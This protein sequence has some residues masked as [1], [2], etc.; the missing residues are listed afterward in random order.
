MGADYG[1]NIEE[2]R[3]EELIRAGGE[4]ET[5]PALNGAQISAALEIVQNYAVGSIGKDAAVALLTAAGVPV[6]AA[7]NT[8]NKQKV[9]KTNENTQA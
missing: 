4:T 7:A 6:D 2:I 1:D 9:E 3:R 5:V 8:I